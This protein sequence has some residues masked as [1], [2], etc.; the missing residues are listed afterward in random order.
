MVFMNN[1]LAVPVIVTIF[2]AIYLFFKRDL[3]PDRTS[4]I[5]KFDDWF[6]GILLVI[7]WGAYIW[8]INDLNAILTNIWFWIAMIILFGAVF[9]H[10]LI[11]K[12]K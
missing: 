5:G 2:A 6:V 8:T 1:P 11:K 12:K 3:I 7:V 4:F 9:I 10:N